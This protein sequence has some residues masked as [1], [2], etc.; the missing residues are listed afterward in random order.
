MNMQ[1]IFEEALAIFG[2]DTLTVEEQFI[3][4]SDLGLDL[5]E[6]F[7]IAMRIDK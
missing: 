7:D 1:D 2:D 3:S 6:M 5:E 4:L